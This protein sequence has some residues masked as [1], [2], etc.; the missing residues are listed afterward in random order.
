MA[1]NTA[2]TAPLGASD[3]ATKMGTMMAVSLAISAPPVFA[4]QLR[5]TGLDRVTVGRLYAPVHE[6]QV[7]PTNVPLT[8]KYAVVM[9]QVKGQSRVIQD[10][11][12]SLVR[13]GDFFCLTSGRPYEMYFDTE[14]ERIGVVLHEERLSKH[15]HSKIDALSG[16]V[17]NRDAITQLTS[18]V[19]DSVETAI[20]AVPSQ[21]L[22]RIMG[23]VLDSVETL[24]MNASGSE[25][26]KD[27]QIL[28]VIDFIDEHLQNPRLS[29]EMIAGGL[30][31]SRRTLYSRFRDAGLSLAEIIQDKRLEASRRDLANTL[32][33][34]ATIS[35]IGMRWG[36]SSPSHFAATFKSKYGLTPSQYRRQS[37][38]VY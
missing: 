4:G 31:V 36:F 27:S 35:E 30:Y 37:R 38:T 5:S 24:V 29:A 26:G 23:Q 12:R 6:A 20:A 19:L 22:G 1:K 2:T 11:Q 15:L 13:P 28:E 3:L 16:A 7:R 33:A 9:W 10:G 17:I 14:C 25:S 21:F 32:M 34:N 18:R 8:G